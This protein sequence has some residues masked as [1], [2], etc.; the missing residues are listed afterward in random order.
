M[1]ATI[2]YHLKS[3]RMV[4]EPAGVTEDVPEPEVRDAALR[5]VAEAMLREAGGGRKELVPLL[6]V[7]DD[8][9]RDHIIPT[10]AIEDVEIILA[11]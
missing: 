10:G 7:T 2:V 6:T 4:R 1:T 11:A 8:E 5:S 9:G 3:G